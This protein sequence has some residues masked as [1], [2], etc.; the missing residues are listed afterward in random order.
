MVHRRF[1]ARDGRG[2][3]NFCGLSKLGLK[4]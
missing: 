1:A 4:I 2:H 3:H